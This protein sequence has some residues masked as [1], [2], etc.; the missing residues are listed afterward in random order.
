MHFWQNKIHTKN[1]DLV[2]CTSPKYL[3]L[4]NEL[5]P[6]KL[7]KIGHG[8]SSQEFNTNKNLVNKIKLKYGDF[9][10]LVGAIA[11]DI[12]IELIKKIIELNI[13]IL[14]I[15]SEKTTNKKWSSLKTDKNIY[16]LGVIPAPTLKNYIAA[17]K[18]CLVSYNFKS[19]QKGQI[20]RSPLKVLNYLAQFKPII[21]SI[22]SDIEEL[23]GYGIYKCNNETEYCNTLQLAIEDKLEFNKQKVTTYLENHKYDILITQIL[24]S[25]N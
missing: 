23:E 9:V 4:Y 20:T 13:K 5:N 2:V 15:G 24:K 6:K 1:A 12:N 16:Y 17:S 10:I 7:I 14:I 21:T 25:L 18:A 8:I 22:D 11:D 3:P 19:N